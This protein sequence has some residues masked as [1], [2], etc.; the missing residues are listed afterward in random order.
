ME[1]LRSIMRGSGGFEQ[2]KLEGKLKPKILKVLKSLTDVSRTLLLN[3]LKIRFDLYNL[4]KL[5]II[6]SDDNNNNK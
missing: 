6:H 2:Y 5:R 1:A 3:I 4:Y